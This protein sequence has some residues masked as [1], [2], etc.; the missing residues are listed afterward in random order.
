MLIIRSI[1]EQQKCKNH[2]MFFFLFKKLNLF[3]LLSHFQNSKLSAKFGARSE[4]VVLTSRPRVWVLSSVFFYRMKPLNE[5]AVS[6]VWV[7]PGL[8]PTR[9]KVSSWMLIMQRGISLRLSHWTV[10]SPWYRYLL[11]LNNSSGL[12]QPVDDTHPA[13]AII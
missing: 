9:S 3:F 5:S 10:P 7:E 2:Q 11:P 8:F 12:Q 1:K 13:G 6:D 4:L